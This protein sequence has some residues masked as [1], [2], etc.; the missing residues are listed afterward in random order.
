MRGYGAL[1]K[2]SSSEQREMGA[3]GVYSVARA[4][5]TAYPSFYFQPYCSHFH[6]GTIMS[7]LYSS[8]SSFPFQSVTSRARQRDVLRPLFSRQ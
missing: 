3:F 2:G 6:P 4:V 7:H 5:M 1:Q 8:N